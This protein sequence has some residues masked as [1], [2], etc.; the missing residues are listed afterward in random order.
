MS[1]ASRETFTA[2]PY[3]LYP[4]VVADVADRYRSPRSVAGTSEASLSP[5]D[6]QPVSIVP[7]VRKN[8][9]TPHGTDV[10]TGIFHEL[11]VRDDRQVI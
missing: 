11:G 10:R 7:A 1:Q 9:E 8:G 3:V 2:D 4:F 6:R 5:V